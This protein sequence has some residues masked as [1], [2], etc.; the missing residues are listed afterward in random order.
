MGKGGREGQGGKG[1]GKEEAKEG[2]GKKGKKRAFQ[3]RFSER[4]RVNERRCS[5]A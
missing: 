4:F 5:A 3:R 1:V 2:K